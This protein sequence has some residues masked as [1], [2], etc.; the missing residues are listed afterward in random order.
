VIPAYMA[1]ELMEPGAKLSEQSDVYGLGVLFHEMLNG[2]PAYPYRLRSD[3]EIRADIRNNGIAPIDRR[4]IPEAGKVQALLTRATERN[5]SARPATVVELGK[6]LQEIFGPIPQPKRSRFKQLSEWSMPVV[7][8]SIVFLLV[9]ILF[10][11][12]VRV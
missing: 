7:V 4:D 2:V 6:Q 10:A 5:P 3:A 12:V 1:P 8:G 11:A 9:L